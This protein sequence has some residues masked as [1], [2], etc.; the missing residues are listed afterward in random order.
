MQSRSSSNY[1][2]I[3]VSHW[4]KTIDYNKV[5]QSRVKIVYIKATQGE[6]LVDPF[7][8]VN[9]QNAKKSGLFVGFYHYFTATTENKAKLEASHFVNTTKPYVCDCK[10]AIDIETNNNLNSSTL[11]TLCKVFLDEVKKLTGLDVVI[12]TYT[13]FAKENLNK[14]LS[15]YPVWIAHYNV[16]TPGDNGI[17]DRWIGFQYSE[18]GKVP[19]VSTDVDLNEFT[20]EILLNNST[21][22]KKTVVIKDTPI[23]PK[24]HTSYI[25]KKGDTLSQI[26]DKFNTNVESLVKLNNIKNPNL[27]TPGQIL[28]IN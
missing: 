17:W 2:G 10:M 22:I 3:D 21:P 18:K 8:K 12:Y 6:A 7:F 26:A 20:N 13:S 27:I 24:T 1:K 4:D 23:K 25:I 14:S 19:G 15:V 11:T 9:V 16:N 28:R 5:K